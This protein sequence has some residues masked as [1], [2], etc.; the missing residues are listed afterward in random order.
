MSVEDDVH[1]SLLLTLIPSLLL[2]EFELMFLFEFVFEFVFELEFLWRPCLLFLFYQR[3]KIKN[4]FTKDEF[5][6]VEK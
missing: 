3:K 5:T 1:N 4:I 6:K 2:F